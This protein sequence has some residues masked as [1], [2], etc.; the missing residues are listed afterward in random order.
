L[1]SIE[2]RR[3]IILA[4][5]A[6]VIGI[7]ALGFSPL[8]VRWANAPGVVSSFY[9]MG[10]GA[11]LM[12]IPFTYSVRVK[13]KSLAAR[14]IFYAVAGGIF[15][16][17]DMFFWS[18]GVMLSG[19]AIPTLLANTA[20]LW[21]G[22]GSWLIFKE[23]HSYKFWIGL[24]IALLGAAMVLGMNLSQAPEFGLG[25]IYGI[26]AALFYGAFYLASQRG[27]EYLDTL[28]Y[29]WIS[30]AVSAVFLWLY[31]LGFGE[32]LTGYGAQTW[33]F[34]IA[35]GV[36]TQAVGWMSINY[37]QG[38]IP[39]AIVSPTMLAQPL[40]VVIL[41]WLFLD[42]R[43]TLWHILGGVMVLGGVFLTHQSKGAGPTSL[44]ENVE[45]ED[46]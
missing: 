2:R 3:P 36:L 25:A 43:F 19:A 40:V 21:V 29:F 22:L 28:S 4:Y 16:S 14:G 41:A 8:F 23:P 46:T 20:P 11:V 27:R 34:F 32:P 38:K 39:A 24:T 17:L 5:F 37:A 10:I 9:R 33:V 45:P 42:E 12:L 44:D 35:M 30:T 26:I 6:L 31:S 13:K 7:F 1:E 18:N 15:F